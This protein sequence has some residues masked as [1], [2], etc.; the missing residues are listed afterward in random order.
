MCD[1]LDHK[2]VNSIRSQLI[3]HIRNKE[4]DVKPMFYTVGGSHVHGFADSNSDIDI[5]GFHCADGNRYMLFDTPQSQIQF[6]TE[7]FLN[8]TETEVVSHELRTFGTR[9]TNYQFNEIEAIFSN[10]VILTRYPNSI[11]SLQSILLEALPGALPNRYYGMAQSLHD[12]YIHPNAPDHGDVTVKHHLYSLRGVLAAQ[13]VS[14]NHDV[15]PNLLRL[16]KSILDDDGQRIVERLIELKR[17]R[18][19]ESDEFEI[20]AKSED[21]IHGL[22]AK[23]YSTEISDDERNNFQNDVADW[24]LEFRK[25]TNTL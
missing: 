3:Q 8:N 6:S 20:E 25:Q 18:D 13:Y 2:V 12:Q 24:M 7:E 10:S 9:L 5:R 19:T 4:D 16:S 11:S 21:L 22:L 1:I 15:E 17:T 14:E 23:N